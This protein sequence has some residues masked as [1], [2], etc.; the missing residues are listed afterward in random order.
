MIPLRANPQTRQDVFE[1]PT[2]K[3]QVLSV[4]SSPAQE[5][6]FEEALEKLEHLVAQMELGDVPL[7]EMVQRFEDGTRLLNLCAEKLRSA[8]RRIE[9]LK[10]DR[11]GMELE[12]F[13][14]EES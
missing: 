2:P 7:E 1:I 11:R 5:P 12:K 14:P 10:Q 6:T 8:E 9:I 3:G 4:K 13:T